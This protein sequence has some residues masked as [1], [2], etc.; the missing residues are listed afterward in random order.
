MEDVRIGRH[1]AP[2]EDTVAVTTASKQLCAGAPN[3]TVLVLC[4]AIGDDVTYSTRNPAVSGQGIVVPAKAGPVRLNV[5]R[6][7]LLV[8]MPWYVIGVA[9]GVNVNVM[10]CLLPEGYRGE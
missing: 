2:S 6:D 7:G 9:G 5:Q 1:S 10:Q 8:T 3:R 4:S